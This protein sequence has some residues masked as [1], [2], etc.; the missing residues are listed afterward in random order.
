MTKDNGLLKKTGNIVEQNPLPDRHSV[1]QCGHI[2]A[3]IMGT[4]T[5]NVKKLDFP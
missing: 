1:L 3:F 2:V 4:I 5:G